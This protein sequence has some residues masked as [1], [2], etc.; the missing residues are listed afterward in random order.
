M[1][2]TSFL[3]SSDDD[4][5]GDTGDVALGAGGVEG[6]SV[7]GTLVLL[8]TVLVAGPALVVAVAVALVGGD[9]HSNV[10]T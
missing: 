5:D 9:V 7:T 8:S 1:A 3:S 6:S 4:T 2:N 10:S